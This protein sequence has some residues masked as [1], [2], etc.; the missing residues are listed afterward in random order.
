[1]SEY[2]EY[3]K[4]RKINEFNKNVLSKSDGRLFNKAFSD[5]V[6]KY[7]EY[8]SENSEEMAKLAG[9]YE[10]QN[11]KI[12]EIDQRRGDG[13]LFRHN[14]EV[15]ERKNEIY[16]YPMADKFDAVVDDFLLNNPNPTEESLFGLLMPIIKEAEV[17]ASEKIE[18][19]LS[20]LA[21]PN[22]YIQRHFQVPSSDKI[23]D[24]VR[25]IIKL[26]KSPEPQLEEAFYLKS[27]IESFF[28][29]I[30]G[31]SEKKGESRVNYVKNEDLEKRTKLPV[32]VN[33]L[34][35]NLGLM[36][37]EVKRSADQEVNQ[38]MGYRCFMLGGGAGDYVDCECLVLVSGEYGKG[39]Y[40][41]DLKK[42]SGSTGDIEHDTESLLSQHK[43]VEYKDKDFLIK[44]NFITT[45]KDSEK[46]II[47]SIM[48][49]LSSVTGVD[50]RNKVAKY[51]IT[52]ERYDFISFKNDWLPESELNKNKRLKKELNVNTELSEKNDNESEVLGLS[53]ILSKIKEKEPQT[54]INDCVQLLNDNYGEDP[55][56]GAELG[57]MTINFL[58]NVSNE[59]DILHPEILPDG[60]MPA[61]SSRSVYREL[62][63]FGLRDGIRLP[64]GSFFRAG[65][66][67]LDKVT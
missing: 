1:M 46:N 18:D 55:K 41:I 52:A 56:Y 26:N 24:V 53:D 13:L 38:N 64:Q 31:N 19:S 10:L 61:I 4:D 16:R 28:E 20:V 59:L 43:A 3:I 34:I 33:D 40:Y 30:N 2:I 63:R 37:R 58:F 42:W 36:C 21:N 48:S 29:E 15:S 22:N 9:Y 62:R 25:N 67:N 54:A 27:D 47:I 35:G 49:G 45:G 5:A 39:T 65:L 32:V 23:F 66:R 14:S 60:G 17:L 6:V 12:N 8:G 11:K 50:C 57:C 7:D 44:R 51:G